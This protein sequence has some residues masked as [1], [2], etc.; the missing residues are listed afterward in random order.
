MTEDVTIGP[1]LRRKGSDKLVL[2]CMTSD[3]GMTDLVRQGN[4][5]DGNKTVPSRLSS[6]GHIS[7]EQYKAHNTSNYVYQE[8]SSP[9]RPLDPGISTATENKGNGRLLVISRRRY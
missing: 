2:H 5:R 4:R 3:V 8:K 9:M 6:Y 7:E 1:S